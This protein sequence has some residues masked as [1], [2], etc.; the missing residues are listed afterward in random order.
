ML[1]F[2]CVKPTSPFPSFL[3]IVPLL[4]WVRSSWW[5]RYF[6]VISIKMS[7]GTVYIG[8][9]KWFA[10]QNTPST[11]WGPWGLVKKTVQE[12]ILKLFATQFNHWIQEFGE[13]TDFFGILGKLIGRIATSRNAKRLKDDIPSRVCFICD[14]ENISKLSLFNFTCYILGL[15]PS[16]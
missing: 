11:Q 7:K 14:F 16:Q 1:V 12:W 13:A 8:Y 5:G 15:S 3:W 2:W 4:P 9:W 10:C 6:S